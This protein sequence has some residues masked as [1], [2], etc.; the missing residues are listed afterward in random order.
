M[1]DY[2]VLCKPVKVW[3]A[4]DKDVTAR[5]DCGDLPNPDRLVYGQQRI[6]IVAYALDL[7]NTLADETRGLVRRILV[8]EAGE[9]AVGGEGGLDGDDDIGGQVC[10]SSDCNCSSAMRS[11]V[12][13]RCRW[14][15]IT[16]FSRRQDGAGGHGACL[17]MCTSSVGTGLAVVIASPWCGI[18]G[19][20]SICVFKCINVVQKIHLA[21]NRPPHPPALRDRWQP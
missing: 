1:Y 19:R 15:L 16:G 14:G 12:W 6:C 13:T 9:F 20:R 11:S 5:R 8:E 21:A 2:R 10:Y 7:G 4:L 17:E 3:Y 18:R